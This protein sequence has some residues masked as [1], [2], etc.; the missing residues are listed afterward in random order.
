MTLRRGTFPLMPWDAL[1]GESPTRG[2]GLFSARSLGPDSGWIVPGGLGQPLRSSPRVRRGSSPGMQQPP[3][4]SH[5]QAAARQVNENIL[6][7]N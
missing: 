3:A 6:L 5:L 4:H 7:A 1:P 2:Y